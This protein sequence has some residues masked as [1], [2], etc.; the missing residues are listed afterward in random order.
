MKIASGSLTDRGMKRQQNQDNFLD[1]PELALYAVADGMG[2]HLGGETA[3]K[4]AIEAIEKVFREYS[5]VSTFEAAAKRMSDAIKTANSN[6]QKEGQKQP[7]LHGM[8]TTASALNVLTLESN[9]FAIIGQVG[10]SRT[11]LIHSGKIWQLN[12]DHSLVQEKLRAGIITRA[13]LKTARDKNVIT[14]SVGYDVDVDVDVFWLKINPGDTFVLCSDGLHGL[15]DDQHIL[16]IVTKNSNDHK[17]AANA[18]IAAA[19]K[20]GGDDNVTA[21][22]VR[23]D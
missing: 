7:A 19:N 2:G 14:R 20:N 9:P 4:I 3:S 1:L 18:L 23:V 16:N 21:V 11:Y 22:V 12:R 13:Q 5:S 8:G 6:I 15:I 10:D 17:A